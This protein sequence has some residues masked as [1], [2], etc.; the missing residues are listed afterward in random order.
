MRPPAND[1]HSRLNRSI[2]VFAAIVWWAITIHL[3]VFW[4]FVGMWLY[5]L[6]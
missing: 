1:N 2:D 5:D 6:F 3:A 4:S